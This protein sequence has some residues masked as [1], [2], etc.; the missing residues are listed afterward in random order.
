MT[1]SDVLKNAIR[2]IHNFPKE[3]VIYRDITPILKDPSLMKLAVDCVAESARK[4]KFDVIA[5]PE[6]RGFIFGVPLALRLG[7][8]FIPIRKAG[9]LPFDTYS[10]SYSLEYGEATIEVHKDAVSPDTRV[11][12][13][14]DLLATGGTSRATIE[15]FHEI[16]ATPIA[17]IFLIELEALGGRSALESLGTGI[18]S[19]IKY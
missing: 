4:Y 11:L 19:I 1:G 10:K 16:G 17:S 8:G 3:G 9:K 13:V 2:N 14:D 7:V 12:V 15:L 18:E 5:G 6:S